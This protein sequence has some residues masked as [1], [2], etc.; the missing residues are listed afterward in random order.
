[1]KKILT[2]IIFIIIIVGGAYWYNQQSTKSNS[3]SNSNQQPTPAEKQEVIKIGVLLPLSGNSSFI[4]V[5]HKQ[6]IEYAVQKINDSNKVKISLLY[7]DTKNDPK[8]SVSAYRKLISKDVDVIFSAMSGTSVPIKSFVEAGN[9]PMYVTSVSVQGFANGKNI[10]RYNTKTEDEIESFK[11]EVDNNNIT[12][13]NLLYINDEYGYEALKTFKSK[14]PYVNINDF[15]FEKNQSDFKDL[16][17]KLP[18][19]NKNYIIGYG[20]SYVNLIKSIVEFQHPKIL[21]SI[22]GLDFSEFKKPIAG[23]G[24]TTG[25]TRV[26]RKSIESYDNFREAFN[27]VYDYQPNMVQILSYDLI[28]IIYRDFTNKNKR[29]KSVYGYD[30]ISNQNGEYNVPIEFVYEEN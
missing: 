29:L 21:Y 22:Y 5:W 2:L 9:I 11:R 1:M 27:E 7:E 16:I 23:S 12:N 25:Y 17:A 4:G 10:F 13:L 28:N 3:S 24:I 15:S 26:K 6:G 20:G 8:T 18:R 14:M 30:L 19:S